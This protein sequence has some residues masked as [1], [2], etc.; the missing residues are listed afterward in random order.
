MLYTDKLVKKCSYHEQSSI[1]DSNKPNNSNQAFPV[2][3]ACANNITTPQCNA[4]YRTSRCPLIFLYNTI[5]ANEKG[6]N[7][8]IILELGTWGNEQNCLIVKLLKIKSR[9]GQVLANV[10]IQEG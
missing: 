8:D 7:F 1:I 5:L 9:K 10:K 6:H 4:A 3:W 2:D